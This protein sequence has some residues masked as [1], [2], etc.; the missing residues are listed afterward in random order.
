VPVVG[1]GWAR[2]DPQ[3][4]PIE[5]LDVL[6]QYEPQSPAEPNHLFNDYIDGGFVIYHSPGYKVFVDDRCEVFGGDWLVNF[7][8]ASSHDTAATMERWQREHGR[9]DFA[10][11]RTGTGFDD[12]FQTAPEWE[13]LK[14]TETASFYRRMENGGPGE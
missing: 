4:W 5:L 6:K 11:T 8:H 1:A 14:K 9:F 2:H 10:L 3:H 12:Y 13:L 7:V